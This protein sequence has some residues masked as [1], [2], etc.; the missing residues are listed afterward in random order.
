[1]PTPRVLSFDVVPYPP[2]GWWNDAPY[3]DTMN[4]EAVREFI[5]L[6]HQAYADRFGKDF[7]GLVPAIFTDEPNYAEPRADAARGEYRLVW[8]AEMPRQF[9]KRRGYD[10]RDHLPE[11]VF[12]AA[13]GEFSRVRHD[14]HRTA[15]ELFVE[16]FSAQIG[17]WCGKHKIAFTGHM[18]QEQTLRTQIESVGACMPHYEHFQWPGIDILCDQDRELITAKQ[19]ASVADQLGKG[20]VLSELYGCT[21][22]DWPLEG[23]K[24]VGDWQYAAGVNFRCP[25]LTHFS[26]AGGAKRDYP[27]SIFS[28][29]PWWKYYPVVEDYFARLSFML[30]QGKPLRDVLVIHPVESGWGCRCAAGRNELLTELDQGLDRITRTLSGQ[31]YDWDFADESLLE[32]RGGLTGHAIKL[33]KLSYQLVLVPPSV[34]LRGTTVELLSQ[35]L[36]AGGK[37]LFVGRRP[38][39]IDALCGKG[40]KDGQG[41]GEPAPALAAV[42]ARSATCDAV[43]RFIPTLEQLLPRRVSITSAG[44]DGQAEAVWAMLRKIEGGQLLF[45]QSHDRRAGQRVRVALGGA[46]PVTLWDPRTGARTGVAADETGK[47]RA[48]SVAFD[49]ALPPTGSALLTIGLTVPDAGEPA[50]EPAVVSA[51]RIEGPFPIELTEPNTLPLDYCCYSFGDEPWSQPMPTLQGRPSS[52]TPTPATSPPISTR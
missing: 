23:H 16:G 2:V 6:T 41:E 10:V 22:W 47:G 31:H 49:L 50:A 52:R 33:G 12:P 19:T 32:R 5:H 14:F 21:G 45:I 51:E 44:A 17:A 1:M 25:H 30:T 11:L 28:H 8:T 40:G 39:R 18:L 15:T 37:V 43:G 35:F 48:A 34:T 26:L 9:R 13:E 24:F 7:G 4:G 3:L 29:S 42:I 36:D 46:G 27:A 20:R 38:G